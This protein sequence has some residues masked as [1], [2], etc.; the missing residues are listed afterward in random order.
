MS[1]DVTVYCQ[2]RIQASIPAH[3]VTPSE[4]PNFSG[5]HFS[6]LLT[7]EQKVP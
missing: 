1:L 4:S 2:T 5:A 7:K 6:P 3:A